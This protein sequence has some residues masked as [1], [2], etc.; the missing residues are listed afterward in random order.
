MTKKRNIKSWLPLLLFVVSFIF[1][2]SYSISAFSI[3]YNKLSEKEIDVKKTQD[4]KEDATGNLA[5]EE[6]TENDD[7]FHDEAIGFIT[8]YIPLYVTYTNV[9]VSSLKRY[10]I[11]DAKH[12]DIFIAIHNIRI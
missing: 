6:E 5:F 8:H 9:K 2:I 1:Q 11:I 7:E 4:K 10:D 12:N 3:S